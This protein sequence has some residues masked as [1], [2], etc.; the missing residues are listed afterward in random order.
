MMM[1]RP[2]LSAGC[3]MDMS[4]ALGRVKQEVL[5]VRRASETTSPEG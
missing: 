3:E 2:A 5:G 1:K 4:Q